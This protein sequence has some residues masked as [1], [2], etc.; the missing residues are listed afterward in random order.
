MLAILLTAVFLKSRHWLDWQFL[1]SFDSYRPEKAGIL[2]GI[3][4]SLWLILLTAMIAVPV[5]VGAAVYLEEYSKGTWLTRLIQVNL[6]NLAGVPSIVYG[7]LGLTVFV[8]MFGWYAASPAQP[9]GRA[10]QL[11]ADALQ[12]ICSLIG[13]TL[14]FGPTVIS[15]ALTL[16]LLVL[17]VVIISTQEALRAV[18]ASLRHA[19]YALG[20]TKWQTIQHQVLPAAM[21]GILTG[22]ILALSRA[23]GET[24]PLVMLGIPVYLK[25]TPGDIVSVSEL[26]TNAR[27]LTEVPTSSFTAL[28]MIVLNWVRQAKPAFQELAAAGIVVLLVLLLCMNAAAIFIRQHFQKKIRW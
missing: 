16:S 7:I 20:A 25:S 17:P 12:N 23:V 1:S 11:L 15:G 28:P 8:R 2:A 4:G 19:S 5:G 13:L 21:P 22:V 27:A 6:S 24:A 9:L 10:E 18:P 3:W 26:V 14:P